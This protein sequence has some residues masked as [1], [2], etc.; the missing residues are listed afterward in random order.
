MLQGRD[1]PL[2]SA[3]ARQA[4]LTSLQPLDV[5]AATLIVLVQWREKVVVEVPGTGSEE[6]AQDK[7]S[8]CF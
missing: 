3:S 7:N 1:K 8:S 5:Q 2:V 4:D 6:R